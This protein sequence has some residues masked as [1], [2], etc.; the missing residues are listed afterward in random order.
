VLT[1]PILDQ[2]TQLG[3]TGMA[4][5]FAELEASG[6]GATLT[7]PTGSVCWSIAR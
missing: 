4:Q 6:E 2:L 3:L 5:T 1:H 7:H